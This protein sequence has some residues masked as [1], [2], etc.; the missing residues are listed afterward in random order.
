MYSIKIK[1]FCSLNASV[2]QNEI[3]SHRQGKIFII[4][5]YEKGLR[6][7]SRIFREFLQFNNKRSN[8]LMK[9]G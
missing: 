5:R 6:L 8:N 4:H 7:V 9:N 2:K 1:I 3:A